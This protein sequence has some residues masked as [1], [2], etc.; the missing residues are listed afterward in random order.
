M[1]RKNI[2]YLL[3]LFLYL[4]FAA[5][6]IV[7]AHP[8]KTDANG[9][10]YDHSTGE[11][12]YHHGYPAHQHPNGIC[13]YNYDDKTRSDSHQL[14]Q[15]APTSSPT[16][17]SSHS[18]K[19]ENESSK[20]SVYIAYIFLGIFFGILA[21]S[22]IFTLITALIETAKNTFHRAK[23]SNINVHEQQYLYYFNLYAF[24]APKDFVKLPKG[25]YFRDGIPIAPG[26]GTYGLY[27]VY[28][29]A[30]GT[31]YHQNPKC[32]N[33]STLRKRHILSARHLTPCSKC[34]KD[35][36]PDITW[37]NEYIRILKIKQNYEIP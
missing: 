3:L 19:I 25:V 24:Y 30:K 26:K 12:H 22:S 1:K 4:L 10:H 23:Y 31:K 32:V 33:S 17:R 35:P 18:D 8:G 6:L 15:T 34:V 9:G 2:P 37:Y 28:T 29:T 5:S 14:L 21:I 36:I 27:T 16:V 7:Y 20:I 13:P 11:Y